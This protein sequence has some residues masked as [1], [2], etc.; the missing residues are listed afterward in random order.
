MKLVSLLTLLPTFLIAQTPDRG[1]VQIEGRSKARES[2]RG[3]GFIVEKEGFLLTTYRNLVVPGTEALHETFHIRSGT[4]EY[5]AEVIGVEPTIDL[6]ILKLETT[7]TFTP[8][9]AAVAREIAPGQKLEAVAFENGAFGTIPGTV[10]ALNTKQCYQH[11]LASTMFRAQITIPAAAIG[12]P[13][14]H[15]D[16]G[17]VAAIYTGFKP[18]PE[19]GHEEVEGETHLLPIELCFNIYESLKTKRSLK[20]PWTGFSVRP[21]TDAERSFFPTVKKHHGGVAVEDVWENSPAQR[22]GVKEGDILVQFSYNR[23]LSVADFQK[24]L[25]M[26]GVGQPVKLIFLRNGTDYLASDYTIEERPEWAK[27]K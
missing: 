6:A 15:A 8:A 23:I 18:V 26:Y 19:P 4:S 1:V 9:I 7:E 17:E 24:W 3:L 21:L 12:G 11:S 2:S 20:S 10:T 25:Y 14:F 5:S 16:S 22:M 27:P 13:V